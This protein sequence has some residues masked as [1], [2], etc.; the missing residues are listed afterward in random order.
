MIKND[1]PSSTWK[2]VEIGD[3]KSYLMDVIWGYLRVKLP[4]L[5]EIALCVLVIPHSNAGEKIIFSII[6]KNETDFRSGWFTQLNYENKNVYS[7]VI[8]CVS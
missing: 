5:S 2:V 8:N 6:R 3:E 1:I 7:T 4:L